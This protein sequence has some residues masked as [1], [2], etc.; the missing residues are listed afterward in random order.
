MSAPSI[1][2][3][4]IARASNMTK[5]RGGH[6]PKLARKPTHVVRW[7]TSG[8]NVVY[9]RGVQEMLGIAP[10]TVWRMEKD[11]RLPPRDFFVRGVPVGWK[12][13]TLAASFEEPAQSTAPPGLPPT[14]AAP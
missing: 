6:K 13:Q 4:P 1:P 3:H 5:K 2:F 14:S 10:Q 8:T 11:Q 7:R 12:P 9:P